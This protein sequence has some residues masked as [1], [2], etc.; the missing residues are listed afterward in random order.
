MIQCFQ[1][2]G[3]PV[4][5]EY[6]AAD[7]PFS[8]I[9][10]KMALV[11]SPEEQSPAVRF[12]WGDGGAA[13][14][15]TFTR[16][17]KVTVGDHAMSLT[18]HNDWKVA[19]IRDPET[20]T[21]TV[22]IAEHPL[23]LMKKAR[24]FRK[25]YLKYS[26]LYGITFL[27]SR[28]KKIMYDVMEPVM[29]AELSRCGK[30]LIHSSC[31]VDDRGRA[32]LFPA[33]GGVGKTSLMSW[34]LSSGFRYLCDDIAVLSADGT[35]SCYPLP[36]NLYGYHKFVCPDMHERLVRSMSR[37]DRLRWNLF[38]HLVRPARITRWV[39][40]ETIYGRDKLALG[41]KLAGVF[42]MQRDSVDHP[43]LCRDS[44]PEAAAR[45]TTNTIVNEI[46]SLPLLTSCCNALSCNA[47]FAD[48]GSTLNRISETAR[49]GFA[50]TSVHELILGR[51][52]TPEEVFGHLR[53]T[54]PDML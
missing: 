34:F 8:V 24:F 9:A 35:V 40:A 1:I 13:M 46:A 37:S 32:L 20:G 29:L 27:E 4:A 25:K 19:M 45:Y 21:L 38:G 23:S 22:H 54:L 31:V 50:T 15:K 33:W 14:P 3:V 11:A 42:H 41:G 48:L 53:K 18:M 6:D 7:S 51:N 49:Q 44:T 36:M 28:A 26:L 43:L 30:T 39:S 5:L 12:R 2:A 17:G 47:C 10:D 52:T 16:L